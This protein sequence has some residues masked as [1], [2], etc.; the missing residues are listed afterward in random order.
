MQLLILE[1]FR[2][3]EMIQFHRRQLQLFVDQYIAEQP[4]EGDDQVG[5]PMSKMFL[6]M[7]GMSRYVG[8]VQKC[9][10]GTRPLRVADVI[11]VTIRDVNRLPLLELSIE[12]PR[13]EFARTW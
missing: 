4:A 13:V 5:E 3:Q 8:S 1:M 11:M 10:S 2:Y 12:L 9:W 6:H 7:R